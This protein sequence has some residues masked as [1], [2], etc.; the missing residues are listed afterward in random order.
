MA[1]PS[2]VETIAWPLR[3]LMA[4]PVRAS[5]P[6]GPP[7]VRRHHHTDQRGGLKSAGVPTSVPDRLWFPSQ[8]GRAGQSWQKLLGEFLRDV[9][10]Q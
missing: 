3:G 8:S 7:A 6:L 5:Q 2:N 4:V 1:G 10:E 9:P